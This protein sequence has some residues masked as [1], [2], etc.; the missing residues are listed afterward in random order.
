MAAGP[1]VCQLPGHGSG[2][3]DVGIGGAQ[4]ERDGSQCGDVTA[5]RADGVGQQA[6]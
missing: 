4:R 3:T 1:G 6:G 2:A 5:G